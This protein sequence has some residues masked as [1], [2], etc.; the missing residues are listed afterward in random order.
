MFEMINLIYRLFHCRE[1][2]G[3]FHIIFQRDIK[4]RK[5]VECQEKYFTSF[6]KNS[7]YLVTTCLVKLLFCKLNRNALLIGTLTEH[8]LHVNISLPQKYDNFNLTCL[9]RLSDKLILSA[10]NHTLFASLFFIPNNVGNQIYGRF[11]D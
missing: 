1:L 11:C 6:E 3:K 7:V 5:L 4:K 10:T 8:F 2:F 9:I